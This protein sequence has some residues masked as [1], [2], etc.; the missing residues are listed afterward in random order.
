MTR[1]FTWQ[2]ARRIMV[3]SLICPLIDKM[4]EGLRAEVLESIRYNL[5]ARED[6]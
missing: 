5:E 3:E 4:D 1:G 6:A 2:E